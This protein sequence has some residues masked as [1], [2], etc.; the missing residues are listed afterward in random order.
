VSPRAAQCRQLAAEGSLGVDG[1]A[2]QRTLVARRDLRQ[3]RRHRRDERRARRQHLAQQFRR[4]A[5]SYQLAQRALR[6]HAALAVKQRRRPATLRR[7][8]RL[9]RL[10]ERRGDTRDE[11]E[12]ASRVGA[13]RRLIAQQVLDLLHP[14]R[15]PSLARESPREDLGRGSHLCDQRALARLDL[16]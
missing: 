3:R 12:R 7:P 4:P 11:L 13:V 6:Q 5:Q 9:S 16:C 8:A 2:Q 15:A 10:F 14:G 1:R